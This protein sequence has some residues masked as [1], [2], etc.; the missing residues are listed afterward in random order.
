[1]KRF[2]GLIAGSI[3]ANGGSAMAAQDLLV[4]K[5]IPAGA[6]ISATDIVAPSD[7]EALRRAASFIGLEAARALYPGQALTATDL[8]APTLVKRN[9]IVQMEYSKGPM[10]ILAKGRALDE[11]GLGERVRVMNLASKKTV[12][13]I[14]S[15]DNSVKAE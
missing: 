9:A 4:A 8:K 1:M 5:R 6:P 2:A 7:H 3:L 13:A 15:G 12:I 14:I 10:N 11:G